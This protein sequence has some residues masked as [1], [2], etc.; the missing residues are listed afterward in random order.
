MRMMTL[1]VLLVSLPVYAGQWTYM[2]EEVTS[3]V[4]SGWSGYP[5]N[6]PTSMALET[7]TS[8]GLPAVVW[9][10]YISPNDGSH[11][12]YAAWDP[13][14]LRWVGPL[15]GRTID[16]IRLPGFNSKPALAL[17]PGD[18][19]IWVG[20]QRPINDPNIKPKVIMIR[21][22]GTAYRG[23]TVLKHGCN[24]GSCGNAAMETD[25]AV[26]PTG[27]FGV[28]VSDGKRLRFVSNA[29]SGSLNVVEDITT[30]GAVVSNVRTEYLPNGTPYV[31][32]G[33]GMVGG[34]YT[35]THIAI[36][37]GPGNWS[38]TD[39][40]PGKMLSLAVSPAGEVSIGRVNP[41]GQ[42]V[43]H[44][45]NG[46]WST[47]VINPAGDVA[48]GDLSLSYDSSGDLGCV[49]YSQTQTDLL[50]LERI[51]GVW[52]NKSGG[53]APEVITT[54]PQ[55]NAKPSLGFDT[56]DNPHVTYAK[57]GVSHRHYVP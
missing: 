22:D 44:T 9:E 37:V 5:S 12:A 54:D 16:F 2:D 1:M 20:V 49:W 36:R 24:P 26:N 46:G 10:A 11:F 17:L 53:T 29:G 47:E 23:S 15:D 21:W 32:W 42:V 33:G 55:T 14:L 48:E 51:G 27:G 19:P 45:N 38:V 39:F 52:L 8:D 6:D 28:V 40:P 34:G 50:Y 43:I 13:A 41:A 3:G 18:V 30:A 25:I 35:N 4:V 7:R 57:G 31:T 56:G